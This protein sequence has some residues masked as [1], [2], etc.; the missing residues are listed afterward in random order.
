MRPERSFA[1]LAAP[2]A[3]RDALASPRLPSRRLRVLCGLLTAGAFCVGLISPVWGADVRWKLNQDGLW[4]VAANW[5]TGTVPGNADD[6]FNDFSLAT[7]TF[8]TNDT[9]NSLLSQARS[10]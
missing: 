10:T 8:N 3:R 5:D 2:R 7:I 6:V 1:C 4:D 9:I